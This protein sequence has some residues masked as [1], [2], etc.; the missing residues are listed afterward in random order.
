[1]IIAMFS[2]LEGPSN[3]P[4]ASTDA[5]SADSHY[6]S[7]MPEY[8]APDRRRPPRRS[9]KVGQSVAR[10]ILGE[11]TRGQLKPGSRLPPEVAMMEQYQVGRGTLREALRILEVNGLLTIKPGPGGGPSVEA[12]STHDFGRMATLFFNA[13]GLT[14]G[15]L[16]EA[17]LTLEPVTARLAAERRD[18]EG[19]R[20]LKQLIDFEENGN[21]D[22]YVRATGDFHT[23][24]AEL[25]GNGVISI[26][27][28]AMAEVFHTRVREIIFPAG[29]A[30]KGVV[31]T[32]NEIAKAIVAGDAD[33]AEQLMYE[34][35][36]AYVKWVE[37]NYPS[38]VDEVIDWIL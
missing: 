5:L 6:H 16:I 21:E 30:R 13:R 31:N 4:Y 1:M 9:E 26:F 11:I 10:E 17:R 35:M 36:Q 38:L 15:E 2:R 7:H 8:D 18:D 19:I 14:I 37:K 23:V 32:H 20:R 27:V 22:E 3:V 24:V 34:H 33:T 12:A 28:L 25:A 29:R